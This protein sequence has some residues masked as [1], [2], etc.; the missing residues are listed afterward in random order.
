MRI[1]NST[2]RLFQQLHQDDDPI[3][4]RARGDVY[5]WLCLQQYRKHPYFDEQ[6][7]HGHPIDHRLCDGRVVH[8]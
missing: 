4:H 3:W 7:M 5:C 8:L 2:Q 1:D 6:T